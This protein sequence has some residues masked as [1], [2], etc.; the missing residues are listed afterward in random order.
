MARASDDTAAALEYTDAIAALPHLTLGGL[1]AAMARQAAELAASHR[2]RGADAVYLAVARR[3]A[4]TLVSRD[5]EQ[6]ARGSGVAVCQTRRKCSAT[7]RAAT[8]LTNASCGCRLNW[9]PASSN[10]TGISLAPATPHRGPGAGVTPA[11][12]PPRTM[13]LFRRRFARR[14]ISRAGSIPVWFAPVQGYPD[15]TLAPGGWG[16]SRGPQL[17]DRGEAPA[18]ESELY[19]PGEFLSDGELSSAAFC[20]CYGGHFGCAGSP[21]SALRPS[22]LSS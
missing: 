2:V 14:P 5:S 21:S 17:P 15:G 16:P 12:V 7:A 8:K 3:Y 13:V 20:L 19:I 1:T 18:P 10:P 11:A 9:I 22:G 6:L 4:T